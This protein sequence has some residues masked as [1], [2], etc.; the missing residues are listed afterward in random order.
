MRR[1][2]PTKWKSRLNRRWLHSVLLS[3]NIPV[4]I[5]PRR[6]TTPGVFA[7]NFGFRPFFVHSLE[8][9]CMRYAAR[10]V[11][12]FAGAKEETKHLRTGLHVRFAYKMPVRCFPGS[13]G[14][15]GSARC[16]PGE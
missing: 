6:I 1:R 15:M 8:C 10:V 13:S 11:S 3:L 9:D 12:S 4:W 7:P 14:A 16:K 2:K 5:K